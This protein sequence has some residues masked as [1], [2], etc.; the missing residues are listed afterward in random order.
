MA[1]WTSCSRKL[2]DDRRH[3]VVEVEKVVRRAYFVFGKPPAI[4]SDQK[5]WHVP[6]SHFRTTSNSKTCASRTLQTKRVP[7]RPEWVSLQE[8]A[9]GMPHGH[10]LFLRCKAEAAL[11]SWAWSS[12][13]GIH[14]NQTGAHVLA[15]VQGLCRVR[16]GG[17]HPVHG[18]E[19][20]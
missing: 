8:T 1:I 5:C 17:A 11:L 20:H 12:R 18:R 6:S 9:A 2:L 3:S 13:S 7:V 4:L 16:L 15:N 10:F 14:H 19:N